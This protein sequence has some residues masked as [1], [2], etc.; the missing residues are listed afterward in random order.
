M[1]G[2]GGSLNK[3]SALANAAAL[4]AIV[5]GVAAIGAVFGV[6]PSAKVDRPE[7]LSV[8]QQDTEGSVASGGRS[9]RIAHD[10]ADDD[11]AKPRVVQDAPNG[12]ANCGVIE[13]VNAIHVPGQGS[14]ASGAGGAAAGSQIARGNSRTALGL[15]GAVGGAY[16]GHVI[17]RPVRSDTSYRIT[18]RMDDGTKRTIHAWSA[19][20]FG[21]GDKVRVVNG[22]IAAQG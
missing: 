5:A 22:A 17:E 2:R 12:C 10:D 20:A 13:A 1:I 7:S 3:L 16:A 4:A 9:E 19:P 15:V 11:G 21:V 8:R 6:I 14:V 18:V